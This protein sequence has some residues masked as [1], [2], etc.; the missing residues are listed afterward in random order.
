MRGQRGNFP[1][2]PARPPPARGTEKREGR[3][4]GGGSGG[5]G[6]GKLGPLVALSLPPDAKRLAPGNGRWAACRPRTDFER[7]RSNHAGG[8]GPDGSGGFARSDRR[9]VAPRLRPPGWVP[10]LAAPSPRGGRT[11][12]RAE[13]VDAPTRPGP[14][15]QH[16]RPV[17]CR[18]GGC[19]RHGCREQPPG[20]Q[21]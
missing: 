14:A 18:G 6:E 5:R 13:G 2:K 3:V 15:R 21:K 16:A 9:G 17:G 10:P 19:S 12:A 7:G 11:A 1:A 8:I 20:R 4:R